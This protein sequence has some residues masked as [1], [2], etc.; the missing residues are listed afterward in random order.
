MDK[1]WVKNGNFRNGNFWVKQMS[2]AVLKRL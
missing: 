2:E 1:F